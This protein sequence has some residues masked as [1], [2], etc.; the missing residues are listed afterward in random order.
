M[1]INHLLL[2]VTTNPHCLLDNGVSYSVDDIINCP[3]KC[4]IHPLNT[5]IDDTTI[6]KFSMIAF[7]AHLSL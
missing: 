2:R 3:D 4:Q 6:G 7:L 5:D 1:T